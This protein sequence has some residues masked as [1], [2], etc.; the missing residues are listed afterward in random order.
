MYKMLAKNAK[1]ANAE[2][3][4][5]NGI[6]DGVFKTLICLFLLY[7]YLIASD[8]TDK[9]YINPNTNKIYNIRE[10]VTVIVAF[11]IGCFQFYSINPNYVKMKKAT[12]VGYK[13][14]E[15]IDREPQFKIAEA[16]DWNQHVAMN[17]KRQL[18]LKDNIS[19]VKVSYK[20]ASAN[21]YAEY[22]LNDM[23]FEIKAGQ[24][25]A[26]IGPTG[27]GKSTIA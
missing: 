1:K 12:E 3:S 16:E 27:S 19:F 24:S 7:A 25:T 8:F 14:F 13:L 18:E 15:V 11:L 21:K 6:N 10:Y 5:Q 26:I 4:Y 2:Y 20:Y 17:S 9:E 22:V 23:S